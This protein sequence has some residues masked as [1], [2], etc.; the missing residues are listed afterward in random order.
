M[1]S[2]KNDPKLCFSRAVG[3]SKKVPA[4]VLDGNKAMIT[5]SQK[6]RSSMPTLLVTEETSQ[7]SQVDA[8]I[9]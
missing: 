1:R 8:K 3:F 4:S 2:A 9:V 6:N 7:T 5:K